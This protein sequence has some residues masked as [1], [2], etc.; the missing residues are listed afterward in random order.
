VSQLRRA[1]GEEDE[2]R[3]RTHAPGYVLTVGPD[4]LDVD[5]FESLLASGSEAVASDRHAAAADS[6]REALALWRGPALADF[7]YEP[8]AQAAIAR[9]EELRLV[10]LEQRIEADLELGREA[11]VVAELEALIAEHPMR[12][13]LRGHLMLALYRCGRQADALEAYQSTRRTLVNELAIEPS[14]ALQDLERA[15]LRHDASLDRPS[16]VPERPLEARARIRPVLTPFPTVRRKP[17]T[18]VFCDL[19][20]SVVLGERLDP[21]LLRS[22]LDRYYST[23]AEIVERHGGCVEKFIGDAVMAAFGVPDAGEDDALRAVRA[24]AELRQHLDGLSVRLEEEF[25]VAVEIRIGVNSGEAVVSADAGM[26][27]MSV[28]G[29]LVNRAARLQQGARPGEILLGAST[30]RL[31]RDAVRVEQALPL[32]VNRKDQAGDAYRLLELIDGAPAIARHLD[33]PLFG[34][35]DELAQ[36]R[37]AFARCRQER[38]CF[39]FNVV[40]MAGIGKSR[41]ALEA[42]LQLSEEAFVLAG[43]CL[44]YGEGVT[45][46]PVREM[47]VA[48]LGE[49]PEEAVTSLLASHP[50][51]AWIAPAVTG[52]FG[53]GAGTASL[54]ESFL[55]VRRLLE[56]LADQRPLVIVLD[57]VHWA[58]RLLLDLIDYLTDLV[59]DA[60]MLVV[61]LARP[62]LYDE[63][64][65]WP[66]SKANA[67]TLLLDRLPPAESERLATWLLDRGPGSGAARTR[68]MSL[69]EGNP[70]FLEQLLAFAGE[71]PSQPDDPFLP[72]TIEALLAARLDRL[73]PAEREL[74]ECAAVIGAEFDLI[75][76]TAL[77]SAPLETT[78]A[79]HLSALV[80]RDLIR[81]TRSNSSLLETFRFRHALIRDAAYRFSAKAQRAQ[82]H[83]RFAHWLTDHRSG[84]D[85][86]EEMT[87][88]HLEQAYT[89]RAA[90]GA[91]GAAVL[92]LAAEASTRLESAA[93]RS[94]A[95]SDLASAAALLERAASLPADVEPRRTRLLADFAATLIEAGRLGEAET[96]LTE[97]TAAAAKTCDKDGE[98]RA[99]VEWRLLELARAASGA[100]DA[101]A[102]VADRLIPFF[103][104]ARNHRGMGRARRLKAVSEWTRGR[105]AAAAAAWEAAAADARAAGDD[106][107]RA[108]ILT[109]VA[110]SLWLGPVP[111]AVGIRRCE[112]IRRQVG[113][114]P[115]SEAE[116]LRPLAGLHGF[117]GRFDVARSLFGT[118]TAAF[119]ELGLGLNSVLSHAEAVVD[120]LE[121]N[122]ALAEQRLRA[123]YD[124]FEAMGENAM[125]STTAA[126]LARAVIAQ[127]R[128]D[129]AER[130]TE[131]SEALAQSDDLL[132]Q[133]M[134]RG[135]RAKCLARRGCLEEASG[136]A[137]D[138]VELAAETDLV[139]FQADALVDLTDVLEAEGRAREAGVALAE[140]IR[141]Y[142][143]KGNIVS[144]SQARGR[145]DT[146]V[147][148]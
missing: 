25:G 124:A 24:A 59:R 81:P 141:F 20:D 86:Y 71:D 29:D 130:L 63:R 58:H 113:G 137:R 128:N 112:E 131:I 32:P 52:L 82:L 26:S 18:I 73:G 118:S 96:I 88:Y 53:V 93:K 103:R 65:D 2:G 64:P 102:S 21:E 36:L 69:A 74:I 127:G 67:T 43:R 5:R 129:D 75:A 139:N 56:H 39:L 55:A 136:L 123:G 111:V 28:T 115:A 47:L 147:C 144:A 44:P 89:C 9:L 62:E 48:A 70:L 106:Y 132:T 15:I 126:L 105:A 54:E 4:E 117:A 10:A 3:L 79:A 13:R 83:E 40:G 78:I 68:A 91:T 46:W 142:E 35:K 16:P 94:L 85:F 23:A 50:D 110:S 121:G 109:W 72:P 107:E 14:P 90:L 12:E 114:H 120:L 145:L 1:F 19:V 31:V 99:L 140:A 87:G 27:S 17:V 148:V 30:W 104:R 116:V 6:L 133:I 125:R 134:W 22:V 143:Q 49:Q 98:A 119:E 34:R 60:P 92:A 80:R 76:V 108:A 33:A 101:A 84:H 138:A 8:F 146:L 66:G 77:A 45:F 51:Q 61:V 38:A 37:Q 100:T 42:R 135:V 122:H 95:R 7:R 41:L 11:G 57:D 97:A